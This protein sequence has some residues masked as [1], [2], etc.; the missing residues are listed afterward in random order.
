MKSFL[1][2]FKSGLE[3]EEFGDSE[4]DVRE[5][6]RRSFSSEGEP[7]SVTEIDGQSSFEIC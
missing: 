7:L 2:K 6:V 1:I 3:I 4:R 5:F